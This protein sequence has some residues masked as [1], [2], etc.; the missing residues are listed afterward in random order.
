MSSAQLSRALDPCV[1]RSLLRFLSRLFNWIYFYLTK[2]IVTY[3]DFE[4]PRKEKKKKKKKKKKMKKKKKS[5]GCTPNQAQKAEFL[6]AAYLIE[7]GGVSSKS[8]FFK[9]R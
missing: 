9:Y 8:P 7:R 4:T 3:Y 5:I 2:I 1:R 6:S